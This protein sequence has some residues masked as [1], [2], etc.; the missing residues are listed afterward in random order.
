MLQHTYKYRIPDGTGK[1]ILYTYKHGPF[2]YSTP[3]KTM[4]NAKSGRLDLG[5]VEDLAFQFS[6]VT[7]L[8]VGQF[9]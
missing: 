2:L 8:C 3:A 1:R 5:W 9:S 7:L 6:G 4:I